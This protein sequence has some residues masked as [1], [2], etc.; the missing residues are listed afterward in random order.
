MNICLCRVYPT[1][2]P[3][4]DFA[5]AATQERQWIVVVVQAG[6]IRFFVTSTYNNPWD[7]SC[8]ILSVYRYLLSL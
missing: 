6:Q 4:L 5:S 8:H 1:T 2:I 3:T 7:Q